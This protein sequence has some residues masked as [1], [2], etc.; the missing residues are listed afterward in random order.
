MDRTKEYVSL[1]FS[2][3]EDIWEDDDTSISKDSNVDVR[4]YY[5]MRDTCEVLRAII[6]KIDEIEER[7]D[8]LEEEVRNIVCELA[9]KEVKT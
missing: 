8:G 1:M 3:L 9:G 4:V 5:F 7:L 2:R 6:K